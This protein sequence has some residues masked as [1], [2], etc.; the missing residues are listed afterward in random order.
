MRALRTVT[1][2]NRP[3]TTTFAAPH[4]RANIYHSSTA[5]PPAGAPRL[6]RRPGMTRRQTPGGA[7]RRRLSWS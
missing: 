7:L 6:C 4:C 2:A 1:H 5:L 3:A